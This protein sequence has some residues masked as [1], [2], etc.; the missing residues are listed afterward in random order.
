MNKQ[1]AEQEL[2]DFQQLINSIESKGLDIGSKALLRITMWE[3]KLIS[4]LKNK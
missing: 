3:N 1:E 4:Y 2:K